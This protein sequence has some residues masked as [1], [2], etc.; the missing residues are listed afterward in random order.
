MTL[1]EIIEKQ[2]SKEYA[3]NI[4]HWHFL[5]AAI[6]R[7][8]RGKVS[9]D[10]DRVPKYA[11]V[12]PQLAKPGQNKSREVK[13]TSYIVRQQIE[14]RKSYFNRVILA[15]DGGESGKVLREYVGHLSRGGF[16]I[17]KSIPSIVREMFDNFDGEN[18][19]IRDS[20]DIIG[21][22]LL[23]MGKTYVLTMPYPKEHELVGK[24]FSTILAREQV[25]DY[26]YEFGRLK[27]I[28]FKAPHCYYEPVEADG[29]EL[30]RHEIEKIVLITEKEFI[31]GWHNDKGKFE[32]QSREPNTMGFVPVAEAWLGHGAQSI[33][34]SI[35][36]L[37][38]VLMNAESVLSQ[39]IRLQALNILAVPDA[40]DIDAQLQS[41][42][43]QLYI[44][45]PNGSKDTRWAAYPA[46]GLDADFKY[47]DWN[48]KRV[49]ELASLRY[50][51]NTQ[52]VSGYSK[53]WDFLDTD[54]VLQIA[55]TGVQDVINQTLKIWYKILNLPEPGNLF[56][57]K[58]EFDPKNLQETLT[59]ILQAIGIGIG[60]TA[61]KKAKMLARDSLK[62]IGLNL[63]PEELKKS[64]EEIEKEETPQLVTDISSTPPEMAPTG[65]Q[66]GL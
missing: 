29:V 43:A 36:T 5:R 6:D 49:Y 42:N 7:N 54:A 35:A 44:R 57:M 22:E 34:D 39:K 46:S 2:T 13:D 14:S 23:G 16:D 47:I 10:E 30:E 52:N 27:F 15:V 56:T 24:P 65:E 66:N 63:T 26:S 51:E 32:I 17:D 58:R 60:E 41:M 4:D 18:T 33:I 50:K 62:D 12:V 61:E 21:W 1:E 59:A 64:N 28:K 8:L 20:A 9:A 31:T 11:Q 19:S 53:A 37:Q 45:E 40:P 25:L 38:F 3:E 55:A 48:V